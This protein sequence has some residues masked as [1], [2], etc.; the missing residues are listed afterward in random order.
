MKTKVNLPFDNVKRDPRFQQRLRRIGLAQQS[1]R[2]GNRRKVQLAHFLLS[3]S[4][5]IGG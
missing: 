5:G 2:F 4:T 3:S 1:R